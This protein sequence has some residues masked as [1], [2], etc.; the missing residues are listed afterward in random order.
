MAQDAGA[1]RARGAR[2]AP[3]MVLATL[4]VTL[5]YVCRELVPI[6]EA[7]DIGEEEA[8]ATLGASPWAVFA[9]VTLPNIK[10]GL[11]YGMVLTNARAVG[12]FGAVAVVS[13][14]IVGRTQT[15]TLFVESAYKEYNTAGAFAAAA[16]SVV[17]APTGPARGP[18]VGAGSSES[19]SE[20]WSDRETVGTR[21]RARRKPLSENREPPGG[22]A[23]AGG[24]MVPDDRALVRARRDV[25]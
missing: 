21:R 16:S 25:D 2:S 10:W 15:L 23:N 19:E 18:T 5:P 13:G 12:E 24:G 4:F 1:P 14:N 9:N 20:A 6:L 3:G 22:W 7:G 17:G 8:A 11:L